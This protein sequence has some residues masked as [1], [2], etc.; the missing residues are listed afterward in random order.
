MTKYDPNN[1]AS[2]DLL[3]LEYSSFPF[4][5]FTIECSAQFN[6][7]PRLLNDADL[8]AMSQITAD[9]DLSEQESENTATAVRIFKELQV[10]DATATATTDG[11]LSSEDKVKLDNLRNATQS[12]NGLM[13]AAD[14]TK[15]DNIKN[16]TSSSDGLMSAADKAKLDNLKNATTTTDGLMS[17]ADKTKLDGI[18]EVTDTSSGL[19]TADAKIK[20]DNINVK[21]VDFSD[22]EVTTAI[23]TAR[24]VTVTKPDGTQEQFQFASSESPIVEYLTATVEGD[25]LVLTTTTGHV[26]NTRYL[27]AE[28]QN[29]ILY[30]KE[31]D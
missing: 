2:A 5:S 8:S 10:L 11:L 9:F 17:A 22:Q 29:N 25:E 28:V 4:I 19:M 1:P 27:T 14:K 3:Y 7:N 13:S 21:S 20:L 24:Q 26:S 30:F 12:S 6:I 18:K 23:H 16:A 31:G 15:L